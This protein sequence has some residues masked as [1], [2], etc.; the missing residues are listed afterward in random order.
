[1]AMSLSSASRF[2]SSAP[3]QRMAGP[4]RAS[5]ARSG[6]SASGTSV[7]TI[8]KNSTPIHAP[9]PTRTA[10][11]ISRR[12]IAVRALMPA[13]PGGGHIEQ[14][15]A[16]SSDP[17]SQLLGRVEADRSMRRGQDQ[18]AAGEMNAHELRQHG[19]AEG[20]ERRG[21]LI[22]QPDRPLDRNQAGKRQA[23]ALPGGEIARGQ[24]GQSVETD[25]RQGR[26]SLGRLPAEKMYPE[27]EVLTHR[28]RGLQR[29]LVTEIVDVLTDGQFR[30]AAIEFEPARIRPHQA[31]DQPK[32]RRLAHAIGAGDEQ[33]FAGTEREAQ[34][35]EDLAA[36]PDA[37][38]IVAGEAHHWLARGSD[39]RI[40]GFRREPDVG[41]ALPARPPTGTSRE[42]SPGFLP[43]LLRSVDF[44]E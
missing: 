38:E 2:A 6:P 22:E 34:T 7:T 32:Q 9:P 29:V 18:P 21:R 40:R 39:R 41:P 30:I 35:A 23:A 44:L 27:C 19:L 10:S 11:L 25:V 31:S 37:G 4:I 1:M 42:R 26:L 43:M 20:V 15:A 36:A 12:R 13:A 16:S 17:Q 5:S 24:P 3:S 28:Q 8:R 33:R 14:A